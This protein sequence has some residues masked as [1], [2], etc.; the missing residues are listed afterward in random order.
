MSLQ[1]EDS[2]VLELLFQRDTFKE[3]SQIE[4][5]RADPAGAGGWGSDSG[6]PFPLEFQGEPVLWGLITPDSASTSYCLWFDRRLL[7]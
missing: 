3:R 7:T 1:V 2:S 6:S 4:E 5:P